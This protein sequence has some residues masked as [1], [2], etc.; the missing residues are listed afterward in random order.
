MKEMQDALDGFMHGVREVLKASRRTSG[1]ISGVHGAV[2]ELVRVPERIEVAV[3]T[4]L[5]GALQ[6]VVME[7]EKTARAAIAF[8]K[9][10]QLGRATFLPL[11]VIRARQVPEHDRRLAENAEGFVGV[12]A[13][14]VSCDPQYKSIIQNLLGN[15]LLAENLEQANR[16][17]SKCQY[18]YRVVTLEGDV[19]N[20]GGSMT[21]GSLQKKGASLLGRQRQIEGLDQEITAAEATMKQLRDKLSD[22]RKEQSI[23]S[24]NMEELRSRSEQSRIDEQ[25]VRAELQQM[26]SEEKQLNEQEQLYSADRSSHLAEQQTM[27]ATTEEAQAKLEKLVADEARLQEAIKLAEERRKASETAKEALQGQLT[28]LKISSAKTDQEKQSFED[29]AARVR[30]DIVRAKQEL[31]N[32]RS[33][34]AQQEEEITRHAEESVQQVEQLN[35]LKLKKQE[36]SEQTDLQRSARADRIRAGTWRERDEGAA[37]AAPANRGAAAPK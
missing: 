20:A 2:A 10:R 18:R 29:Q 16:I 8:L 1:G 12:A 34:L 26:L 33:L 13:D 19:V 27:Q 9:Q 32:V 28:D 17:A 36:C 35:H 6:H 3:E 14:L 30:A 11:D 23:R 4:A 24:Q 22:L 21:G 37:H 7:D 5:G 31:G 25:Q 15:V